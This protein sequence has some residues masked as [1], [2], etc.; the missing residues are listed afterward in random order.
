MDRG[1]I[2]SRRGRGL[3]RSGAM[4]QVDIRVL[5]GGYILYEI[6][7]LCATCYIIV[8]YSAR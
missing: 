2:M 1:I 6:R 7:L 8:L 3:R 4:Q 5:I